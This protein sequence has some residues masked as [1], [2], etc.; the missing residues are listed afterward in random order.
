MNGDVDLIAE[1]RQRLVN[2]VVD[3]LVDEMVQS[4]RA[5]RPDVH[6]RALPDRFQ[7]FEDL[8]FVRA[9]IVD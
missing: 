2:R 6:R 4:R 9:V 5:G 7:A 8:N 3:N 1:A